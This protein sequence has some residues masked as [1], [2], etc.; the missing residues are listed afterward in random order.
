MLSL[1][2]KLALGGHLLLLDCGNRV[3]AITIT[4][5]LRHLTHD[6]I[7][8]LQNIHSARAFTCY[9]VVA[10][11]AKA[12]Q[13]RAALPVLIVDLLATFY[14]ESITLHQSH[15]LLKE[16]LDSIEKICMTAPVVISARP[17]PTAYRERHALVEQLAGA[18][19]ALWLEENPPT[20]SPRQD[21]LFA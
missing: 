16:A 2:A 20:T 13:N 19:D 7:T 6:P 8:A 17:P 15:R 21:S 9:Q 4:R 12:A 11:L 3:N 5:K 14:D 18:A 10:L 1:A